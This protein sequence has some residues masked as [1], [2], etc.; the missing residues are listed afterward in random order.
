M[1]S[2]VGRTF[3]RRRFLLTTCGMLPATLLRARQEPQA[4]TFSS[5]VHVVNLFATV[6]GK[7]GR[8]VRT[9]T[10]DD[11]TVLE[12]GRPQTVRYFSQQSDLPL[13]LGLL[14]DTSGSERRMISTEREASR[15]FLEQVLRPEKD[16]AFLIHFDREVELLQDLTSSR[17]RL[18]QALA[19]LEASDDT[20]GGA[21]GRGGGNP[22]GGGGNWPGAGGGGWPGRGGGGGGHRGGS[23]GGGHRGGGTALYDAVYLAGDELMRKQTGRKALILLTDGEDNG[24]KTSLAETILCAERAETL[25]YS[26]RIADDVIGN[27]ASFGGR[28]RGGGGGRGGDRPDG[29]KTLQ[30]LSKQTGG[31]YFEVSKKQTVSAIYSQIEEELRNQYNI[32]YTSDRTSTDGTFRKLQVTVKQKGLTVQ[33]RDGYYARTATS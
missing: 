32:G 17:E 9:L 4:P 16:K 19:L 14:V 11:F 2:S 12:D 31:S 8:I 6:R 20:S 1:V 5:D 26:V 33:T 28:G 13:T 3:G 27:L 30:Q 25:A 18:E 29:K 24:S 22:G 15:S 21:S 7:D 10:K 23:R